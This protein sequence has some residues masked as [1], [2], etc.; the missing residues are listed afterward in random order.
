MNWYLAKIIYQIRCGNGNRNGQ[1]D[2]QLRLISASDKIE[3][4][5]KAQ[6]IGRKEEEIF[7]N[8]KQQ[9]VQWKFINIAELYKLTELIDGAE[10]YSRIEESDHPDSYI[11]IIHNKAEQIISG[12]TLEQLDLV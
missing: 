4:I 6:S 2:E 10:L 1:F 5:Q 3:A 9:L 12:K 11:N 8:Q 7:F